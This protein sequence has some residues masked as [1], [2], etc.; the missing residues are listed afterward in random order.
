MSTRILSV[1]VG[2]TSPKTVFSITKGAGVIPAFWLVFVVFGVE[3]ETLEFELETLEFPE[4]VP[5]FEL[6]FIDPF[7]SKRNCPNYWKCQ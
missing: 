4:L 5:E 7:E 3:L 2:E 1:F 6:E